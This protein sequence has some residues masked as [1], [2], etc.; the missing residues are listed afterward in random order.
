MEEVPQEAIPGDAPM[1]P[2]V[3][4][5][6][7]DLFRPS[8]PAAPQMDPPTRLIPLA[9]LVR[10]EP[11]G[12]MVLLVWRDEAGNLS[13]RLAHPNYVF[14]LME[15]MGRAAALAAKTADQLAAWDAGVTRHG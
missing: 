14:A 11:V 15:G 2:R 13:E 7:R 5:W 4:A 12:C 8:V 9:G 10:V 1:T 3:R 6:L